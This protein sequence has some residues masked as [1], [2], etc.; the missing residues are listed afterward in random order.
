[1][2]NGC[3]KKSNGKIRL[4]SSSARG[5]ETHPS[6]NEPGKKWISNGFVVKRML[7]GF[8][9]PKSRKSIPWSSRS[10]KSLPW[11]CQIKEILNKTMIGLVERPFDTVER[12]L[13]GFPMSN[14]WLRT[15][16]NLANGFDKCGTDWEQVPSSGAVN[17]CTS[18]RSW[19]APHQHTALLAP[20]TRK[21]PYKKL[22]H[23]KTFKT[24]GKIN[25]SCMGGQLFP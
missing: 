16:R 25:V 18:S 6:Y 11:N 22:E 1:M 12:P 3:S 17:D 10:R 24:I 4:I 5:G 20:Q 15:A 21:R 19:P 14:G 2:S 23:R 7:N 9:A 8:G 13:N